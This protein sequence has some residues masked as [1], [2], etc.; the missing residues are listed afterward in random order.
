M[1]TDGSSE[2]GN[3]DGRGASGPAVALTVAGSDSGGGAG[4]QADLSTFH[5]FGV[6]GTTAITAVTAQNTVGVTDIHVLP[7]AAVVAQIN[8]VLDDLPV[9]AA[10]TGM[11]AT[12]ELTR[13][14]AREL[15]G[16]V[17][18]LV[19]DPVFVSKHG[20]TLLADD[21]ISAVREHLLPVAQVVTPNLPEAARL[22]D[23]P[24][25]DSTDDILG[26]ARELLALGVEVVVVKGGHRVG[27]TSD[28]LVLSAD[29][30]RWLS[31]ARIA[32]RHTHGT[33]CTLSAAIAAQLALGVGVL[34]AIVGAKDFVAQGIANGIDIGAGV[35]P[36]NSLGRGA[37][38]A[39]ELVLSRVGRGRAAW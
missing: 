36:V 11:L 10:K 24:S 17:A 5:A 15:G 8:A 19:V 38:A 32:A 39:A 22:V 1:N 37:R 21:A 18:A 13:A 28:D 35:G 2:Q 25:L 16:R 12:A 26:A 4:I 33:G 29:G 9:G 3:P 7:A 20:D 27:P 31:H 23:R 6:F 30:P 14:V 34:D